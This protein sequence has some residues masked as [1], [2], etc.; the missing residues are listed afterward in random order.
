MPWLTAFPIWIKFQRCLLKFCLVVFAHML[1]NELPNLNSICISL[2]NQRKYILSHLIPIRHIH[3]YISI[4][5]DIYL[6]CFRIKL[7]WLLF[8]IVYWYCWCFLNTTK[9]M[10]NLLG[11]QMVR[12]LNHILIRKVYVCFW[13]TVTSY[14]YL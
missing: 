1:K 3:V 7:K 13:R 2:G 11:F 4:K 6:I 8:H 9:C 5:L 14:F 10:H 12:T